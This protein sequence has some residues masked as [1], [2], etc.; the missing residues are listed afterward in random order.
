MRNGR[1]YSAWFEANG[2]EQTTDCKRGEMAGPTYHPEATSS[3][4]DRPRTATTKPSPTPTQTLKYP[5]L[6]NPQCLE[7]VDRVSQRNANNGGKTILLYVS[8]SSFALTC[9][10]NLNSNS[11]RSLLHYYRA[12]TRNQQRRR[13]DLW[14]LWNGR[15]VYLVNSMSV[16]RFPVVWLVSYLR[17][18]LWV[19]CMGRRIVQARNDFSWRYI[20]NSS[21]LYTRV[22]AHER[23]TQITPQSHQNV[24]RLGSSLS[25]EYQFSA[26]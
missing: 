19:D 8:P 1:W 20:C 23:C 6:S 7:S 25:F 9:N 26:I 13:M 18:F 15:L 5:I 2:D 17:S 11:P 21:L 10:S 16:T 24:S 12:S 4:R 3:N 22:S 14:T